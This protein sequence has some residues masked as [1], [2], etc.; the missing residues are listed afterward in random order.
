MSGA[1]FVRIHPAPTGSSKPLITTPINGEYS[2]NCVMLHEQRSS[3]LINISK[4]EIVYVI[5]WLTVAVAIG[6]STQLASSS[7][8]PNIDPEDR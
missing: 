8:D 7:R 3:G 1:T 4:A 5:D 2:E 6:S